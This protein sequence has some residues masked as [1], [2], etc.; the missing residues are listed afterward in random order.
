MRFMCG[1]IDSSFG[2][3]MPPRN[4]WTVIPSSVSSKC[5]KMCF[6]SSDG[7]NFCSSSFHWLS[8]N[9]LLFFSSLDQT[10][11][12][13]RFFHSKFFTYFYKLSPY[14]LL[15]LSLLTICLIHSFTKQSLN[16][17]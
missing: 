4:L 17:G 2:T 10:L 1:W 8:L 3:G 14:Q 15:C 12:L 9:N 7:Y 5:F 16:H 13:S 6:L 11:M